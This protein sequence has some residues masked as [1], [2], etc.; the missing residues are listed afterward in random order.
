MKNEVDVVKQLEKKN[1]NR[2]KVWIAI[3]CIV[4]AVVL[5]KAAFNKLSVLVIIVFYV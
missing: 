4:L 1:Y 5:D 3:V 2:G